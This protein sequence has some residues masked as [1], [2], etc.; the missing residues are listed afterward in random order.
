MGNEALIDNGQLIIELDGYSPIAG[1]SYTILAT[2]NGNGVLGE[3]LSFDE[4]LAP[5][6]SGLSWELDYNPDSVVLSVVPEPSSLLLMLVS[7]CF[8]GGCIRTRVS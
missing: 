8:L 2:D 1:D 4:S 5:L 7:T 3:F 6:A